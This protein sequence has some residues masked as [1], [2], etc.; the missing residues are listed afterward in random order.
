M[1]VTRRPSGRGLSEVASPQVVGGVPRGGLV[2][3]EAR[4]YSWR[5]GYVAWAWPRA[6]WAER[7]GRRDPEAG[8]SRLRLG[9]EYSPV[10]ARW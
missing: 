3:E 10:L 5:R 1:G 2:P 6:W 9:P 7:R 8:E 4:L